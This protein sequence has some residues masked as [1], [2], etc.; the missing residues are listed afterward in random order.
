VFGLPGPLVFQHKIGAGVF[1]TENTVR[2]MSG[3]IRAAEIMP[4]VR[5]TAEN[6]I[7]RCSGSV[8]EVWSLFEFVR[9]KVRYT[10][11]PYRREFIKTPEVHLRQIFETGM[12][13]GDCDDFTVLL[14]AL[15][16]S[17]GYAVRIVVIRS[18]WNKKDEFNH[19]F[20]EVHLKNAWR[21]LDAT[22]KDKPMFY[23]PAAIKT[24]VFEV[25]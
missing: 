16:R 13:F 24:R 17:I 12:G 3:L 19:V 2:A 7:R 4:I 15:L 20:L 5:G 25:R 18:P 8:C 23:R 21:A 14:G 9:R 10:R 22:A 1:G 11:D 6:L